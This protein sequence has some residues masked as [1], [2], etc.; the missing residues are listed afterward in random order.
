MGLTGQPKGPNDYTGGIGSLLIPGAALGTVLYVDGVA[1]SDSNNGFE[2][3]HPLLTIA[4]AL[5]L[6][7]NDHNDT[8]V[9]LDYYDLESDVAVTINK[10]KVTLIGSPGGCTDR[11][12]TCIHATADTACF[13][14]AANDVRIHNFTFEAGASHGGIEFSGGK[15]RLGVFD[16]WF[17]AG[18]YGI[19][20]AA[21]GIAFSLE[22]ARCH[23]CQ[24]LTA[25]NIY[26]NDDPAFIYIHDNTFDQAQGCAIEIVQGGGGRIMDNVISCG[27]DAVS[28]A[29]VLGAS[30]TRC[31]V[32]RNYANFGDADMASNPF[33]DGAAADVNH[34]MGNM[35]GIT[36]IH[37]A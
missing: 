15:C 37:P 13:I 8:I 4:A 5:A 3:T 2:P 33:T 27:S 31:L 34:W 11:S 18:A 28:T 36:L 17:A 26:I 16:C 1:G 35:K 22:V 14:I 29:I 6:C 9:V 21:G 32:A 25:Q 30:V 19:W 24:S 10:S 7:T 12:W 20:S 23:F